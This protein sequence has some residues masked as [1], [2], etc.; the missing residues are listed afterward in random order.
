[1]VGLV[2]VAVLVGVAVARVAFSPGSRARAAGGPATV[3]AEKGFLQIDVNA[4]G[5]IQNREIVIVKSEVEGQAAI[6]TLVE[7]GVQVSEGD[8]LIELDSS[9]LTEQLDAQALKVMS[10][11]AAYIRAREQLEVIR[12][13]GESDVA[14]AKLALEFA[15]EDLKQYEE[16][17]Y[18]QILKEMEAKIKLAEEDLQRAE[19]KFKWS[20]ALGEQDY[21]SRTEL[22]ADRLAAKK[23]ELELEV[24]IGKRDLLRDYTY[25]RE[26]TQLNSDIEQNTMAL[27]RT[28]RRA[29]ADMVQAEADLKAK[30]SEFES[31]K[32]RLEKLKEQIEKCRIVAPVSG[33]VVYATTGRGGRWGNAEPMEEGQLVRERQEL[34]HLPTA[35]AMK[36]VV[37]VHESDVKKIRRGMPADVTID[38]LAGRVFHGKVS[39]IGVLPDAQMVWLNP[40]LKVY[41]TE[42]NIEG[43]VVDLRPGM[44]CRVDVV[45]DELE[46][47]VYVPVQCVVRHGG[48][49]H[50]MVRQGEVMVPRAVEIGLDN[51]RMVHVISGLEPG[52]EVSLT[53]PFEDGDA[54]NTSE[55]QEERRRSR[56]EATAAEAGGDTE[57][58]GGGEEAAGEQAE[59]V[60]Q[61]EAPGESVA[62]D[63]SKLQGMSPEKRREFFESL[64]PEQRSA[65]MERFRGMRP[66]GGGPGPGGPGGGGGRM[67]P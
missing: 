27:E 18:P 41:E 29:A 14:K 64:T 63:L 9:N 52:E 55:Q 21:L 60:E 39:R 42:V 5:T 32:E 61:E 22:E 34:I 1:V 48:V 28:R 33:M 36:A 2:V 67:A 51:K 20:Q 19:E 11:E 46:D 30:E 56:R 65:L 57:A 49:P 24:A 47:V 35:S 26:L 16:G 50:V 23:A 38:A 43:D 62:V 58:A 31:Q 4:A 44:S 6:L 17:Q 40:D 54:E 10:A 45:V 7:E 59:E 12:S 15:I 53:P 3:T 37:K 25:K 13:Q 8:L 66:P